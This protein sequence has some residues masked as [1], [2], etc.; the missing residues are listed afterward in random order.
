MGIFEL[1]NSFEFDF[2]YGS[3]S[4]ETL[5]DHIRTMI[6]P[7]SHVIIGPLNTYRIQELM[8]RAQEEI[9]IQ[10]QYIRSQEWYDSI[11]KALARGVRVKLM[12]PSLCYFTANTNGVGWLDEKQISNPESYI[13]KW[14]KPLA[15]HSSGLAELRFYRDPI[16][17]KKE[18]G[19]GYIHSKVVLVDNNIA[20]I[21]SVNGSDRAINFNREFGVI[22][23]DQK[24]IQF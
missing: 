8:D 18:K 14:L 9:Q 11:N 24:N 7:N 15:D 6:N 22:I 4:T 12:L 3:P 1:R 20:F 19:L 5:P 16:P 21:G 10:A 23:Q 2:R 17:K 13:N